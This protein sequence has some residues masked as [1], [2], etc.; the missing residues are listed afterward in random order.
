MQAAEQDYPDFNF[1]VIERS[2]E[3]FGSFIYSW[4]YKKILNIALPAKGRKFLTNADGHGRT[5]FSGSSWAWLPF[6]GVSSQGISSPSISFICPVVR[7]CQCHV[8]KLGEN[9]EKHCLPCDRVTEGVT[10]V[11]CFSREEHRCYL[12]ARWFRCWGLEA[13]VAESGD[14]PFLV[15]GPLSSLGL[16]TTLA[17]IRNNNVFLCM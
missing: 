3:P 4:P 7:S 14:L 15:G 13:A 8:Q 1:L 11:E 17:S 10:T 16:M 6:P 5:L 12:D 2:K 9:Q